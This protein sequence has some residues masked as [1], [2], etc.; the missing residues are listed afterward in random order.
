MKSPMNQ[1]TFIV[2]D[3]PVWTSMLNQILKDLGYSNIR[4]FSSGSACVNNLYL[5]PGLI[6]LDYRME[7]MD[8]LKV[9]QLIKAYDADIPV[10]FCTEQKEL[11]V[12]INAMKYGSADY[13]VKSNFT[14]NELTIIIKRIGE[15]LELNEKFN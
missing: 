4:E 2:D 3:D 11:R 8:G 1:E 14:I 9:L 5:N 12:A 7:D 10:I 15:A 6:F 13:L